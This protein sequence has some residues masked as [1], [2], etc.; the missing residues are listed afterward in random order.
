MVCAERKIKK[1]TARKFKA[2]LRKMLRA[3][4]ILNLDGIPFLILH[5]EFDGEG[6]QFHVHGIISSFRTTQLPATNQTCATAHLRSPNE[7]TSPA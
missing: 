4:G 6:F 7:F 2:E 1:A 5:C 3:A